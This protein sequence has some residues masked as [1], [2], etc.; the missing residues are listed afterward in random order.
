MNLPQR[1][2]V[3][4]ATTSQPNQESQDL[5]RLFHQTNKT[6]PILSYKNM[7]DES[8]KPVLNTFAGY[9]PNHEIPT[10]SINDT[11]DVTANLISITAAIQDP[12]YHVNPKKPVIWLLRFI[13]EHGLDCVKDSYLEDIHFAQDVDTD[14]SLKHR[15]WFLKL[16]SA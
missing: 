4:I 10:F 8:V 6:L 7:T 3:P 9:E 16:Q 5:A 13:K 14:V 15:L 11:K 12:K 1:E 2:D